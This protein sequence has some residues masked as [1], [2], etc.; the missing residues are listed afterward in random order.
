MKNAIRTE[1][2]PYR[3]CDDG[4]HINPWIGYEVLARDRTVAW[5]API[6]VGRTRKWYVTEGTIKPC[7]TPQTSVIDMTQFTGVGFR[8]LKLAIES[9]L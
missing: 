2:A 8:T 9:T 7:D 4:T 3:I 6:M 5:V 1:L